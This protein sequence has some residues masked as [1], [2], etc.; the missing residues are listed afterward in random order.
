A[1]QPAITR[2]TRIALDHPG[3]P[4]EQ[5]EVIEN[6]GVVRL[7][8]KGLLEFPT[9]GAEVAAQHVRVALIRSEEHTSDLQSP[10]NLVCRLLLEKK[11]SSLRDRRVMLAIIGVG[12]EIND[13]LF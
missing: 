9:R 3:T 2:L 11:K 13:W 1:G 7:A 12:L 5:L 4:I 6:G 10:C 8:L